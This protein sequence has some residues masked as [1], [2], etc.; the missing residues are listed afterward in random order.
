MLRFVSFLFILFCTDHLLA[1]SEYRL[2]ARNLALSGSTITIADSWSPLNNVGTIGNV[3]RST[4]SV[5]YQNR[6]N[7]KEFM[8]LGASGILSTPW[9]NGGIGFYRF[10]NSLYSEQ[11]INVALG[12]RIQMVSLGV[13]L[14]L[15]Q[16]HIEGLGSWNYWALEFGGVAQ[17]T[18]KFFI[19]THIFNIKVDPLLPIIMKMGISYRPIKTLM[20]NLESEKSWMF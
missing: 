12:H 16:Y 9:V 8:V 7:I 18:D 14:N 19:G 13:G 10:G 6:Y 17:L 3:T 15:I 4:S 1:Q 20:I 5:T 11:K 2:G